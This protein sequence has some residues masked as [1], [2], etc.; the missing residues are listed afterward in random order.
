[1]SLMFENPE[2]NIILDNI[3]SN[4]NINKDNE[5]A[6]CRDNLLV[7]TIDL[8]CKHRYHTECLLNSFIKYDTKKCP[9]CNKHFSI[10]SYKTTCMTKMKNNTI[11]T[12]VCYNN[13]KICKVHVKTYLKELER[14]DKKEIYKLKKIIKNK[15]T[16]LKKLINDQNELQTEITTLELQLQ[17][18]Q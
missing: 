11:C 17:N 12:K 2:Y 7:D 15:N 13:E 18:I 6:I 16:K 5:C 1:M 8:H 3:N 9:L 4:K 10:D 14:N